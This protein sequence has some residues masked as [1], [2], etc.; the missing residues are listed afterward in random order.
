MEN[1]TIVRKQE[2]DSERNRVSGLLSDLKSFIEKQIADESTLR[3]TQL[4]STI[5]TESDFKKE[6]IIR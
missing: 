3:V 4:V 6:S 2:Q 1:E 5:L